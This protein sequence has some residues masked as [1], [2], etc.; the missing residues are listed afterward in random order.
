MGERL[1][2]RV[3]QGGR[4]REGCGRRTEVTNFFDFCIVLYYVFFLFIM[5]A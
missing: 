5:L 4:E 1:G 2:E 3:R